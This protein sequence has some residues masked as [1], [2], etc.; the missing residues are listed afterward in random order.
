MSNVDTRLAA[1]V[2]CGLVLGCLP[3]SAAPRSATPVVDVGVETAEELLN[4]GRNS[5][6]AGNFA[7]SEKFLS[8]FLDHY[9]ESAEAVEALPRLLPLLA[10]SLIQQKKFG[11]ALPV[12][13][14]FVAE[15]S[16]PEPQWE[17]EMRFWLGVCQMEAGD[18]EAAEKSLRAFIDTF[19][20]SP[21]VEEAILLVGTVSSIRGDYEN[22]AAYLK[23]VAGN[24]TPVN[25]GR[26]DVLRLHAL[27]ESQRWDDAMDLVMEEFPRVAD[28][29]Q[30]VSFQTLALQ[31]GAEFMDREEFRKAIACLQRVWPRERLLRHQR[32]RLADLKRRLEAASE[33]NAQPFDML[34]LAQ[35]VVKVE[36]E[37]EQFQKIEQFD[38]ALRLRVGS[39]YLQMQRYREA[40]LVMEDMLLRMEPGPLVEQ[41]SL[42]VVKCWNAIQAHKST[43][44]AADRFVAAFPKSKQLST[45]L[46][47]K[48]DALRELGQY[49]EA[50]V[51]F[52]G[53]ARDDPKSKLAARALFMKGYCELEAEDNEAAIATFKNVLEAFDDEDIAEMARYWEGMAWSFLKDHDRCRKV[54]REYLKLY[55]QGKYAGDA[56]FRIAYCSQSLGEHERASREFRK[57]LEMYPRHARRDEAFLLLG[58]ALMAVGELDKGIIALQGV[59]DSNL[60]FFE[61][62]QF[63]IGKALRLQEKPDL[64]AKHMARFAADYP[65]SPRVPEAIYWQGWTYRMADRPDKA[66]ELYW[67]AIG[68][69]GPDP[70]RRAVTDLFI[71]LQKLYPGEEGR[72]EYLGRLDRLGDEARLAGQEALVLRVLWAKAQ[73]LRRSDPERARALLVEAAD[74]IDPPTTNPQLTADIGDA[75]RESGDLDRA[76]S[77]Y[78]DL[79][80]WNPRAPQKDRAFAGLGLIAVAQGRD[81]D[82]L[83]AFARFERETVGSPLLGEILL[84]KAR[85]LAKN[86]RYD[87]AMAALDK[88]LA[89]ETV[90]KAIKAEALF[91][92]GEVHMQARHPDKAIAY[93]QRVYVLYGRFAPLVSKSYLRSA[94][95]FEELDR[96]QDAI[97]TYRELL[98]RPELKDLPE[99]QAAKRQLEQ[100][101]PAAPD[102]GDA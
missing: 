75:L 82:A 96:I 52:E 91:A 16:K 99:A 101:A 62:A 97:A 70:A 44:E 18:H 24:L 25:R 30:I 19:P 20:R 48:A 61:E 49:A 64:L 38:P 5:Y 35:L 46:F 60:K 27:V 26:A 31:V 43:I 42:N 67:E 53:I 81:E 80:K 84:T 29:V 4:R 47:M 55:P 11:E 3:A 72:A 83:D 86:E 78:A 8:A 45:A 39:A 36:R 14:R 17:E 13:E 74:L 59:G 58:D 71:G 9:G 77:V 93:Y 68:R 79:R 73:V 15:V 33:R 95:A 6:A 41:A 56:D 66:R 98:S 7:D 23:A 37:I 90:P 94:Q 40:A 54:M 87:E 88:L 50:G 34:T 21:K 65:A 12:I 92:M 85:L 102:A 1:G 63:K 76:A 89:E 10:I 69:L 28:I 57:F 100:L 2:C 51:V 32:E 22:T